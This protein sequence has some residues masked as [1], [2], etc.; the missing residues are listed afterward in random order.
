VKNAIHPGHRA[1]SRGIDAFYQGMSMWRAQHDA[2]QLA[3]NVDVIDIASLPDQEPSVFE[4]AQRTPDMALCHPPAPAV[5]RSL[6]RG[7]PCFRET[8]VSECRYAIHPNPDPRDLSSA[9][10]RHDRMACCLGFEYGSARAPA[11]DRK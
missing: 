10:E 7:S 4:P 11:F 9:T 2:V 1:G 5:D 3:G 6:T 8:A